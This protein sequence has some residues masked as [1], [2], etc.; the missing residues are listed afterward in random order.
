MKYH[1]AECGSN[2]RRLR[3]QRLA[4]QSGDITTAPL[5]FLKEQVSWNSIMLDFAE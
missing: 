4:L 3:R 2:P 1:W 5:R